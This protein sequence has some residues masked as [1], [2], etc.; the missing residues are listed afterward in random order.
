[1]LSFTRKVIEAEI[2]VRIARNMKFHARKFCFQIDL[3]PAKTLRD[4][5]NVVKRGCTN[6]ATLNFSKPM[7]ESTACS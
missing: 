7:E 1:M 6:I 3:P 4:V 2:S 5:N